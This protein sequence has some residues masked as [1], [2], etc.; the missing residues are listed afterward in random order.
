MTTYYVN[1]STGNDTNDGSST[2]PWKT[3]GKA[4]TSISASDTIKLSGS[5]TYSLSATFDITS[6]SVTI[7][8]DGGSSRPTIDASSATRAFFIQGATNVTLKNLII[9]GASADNV[10]V[11]GNVDGCLIEGCDLI[12][13]QNNDGFECD[14]V[15]KGGSA[16]SGTVI[17]RNCLVK[18]NLVDGV[19]QYSGAVIKCYGVV[20]DGHGDVGGAPA[21]A[22]NFTT[23]ETGHIEMYYCKS[24]AGKDGLHFTNTAGTNIV[25]GCSITGASIDPIKH[26]SA[27]GST[28]VRN[29]YIE[30]GALT[31]IY[32]DN[33]ANIDAYNN[34]VVMLSTFASGG[35]SQGA[36]HADDTG[37][38]MTVYNNTILNFSANQ[39]EAISTD[40]AAGNFDCRNNLTILLH[41]SAKHTDARITFASGTKEIDYNSYYPD[42]DPLVDG[43][44]FRRGGTEMTFSTTGTNWQGFSWDANGVVLTS[45]PIGIS[46]SSG[47]SRYSLI[48]IDFSE[49]LVGQNL[50]STFTN[51]MRG[52]KRVAT[53][54]WYVGCH[55]PKSME[56]NM[57]ALGI[58][59]YVGMNIRT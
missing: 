13:S 10:L 41:N 58:S 51:D 56:E 29:S 36:I 53:G 22:D 43:G 11:T 28:T 50:S 32:A 46:S 8:Q 33:G 52:N 42:N 18:D 23:H 38:T 19:S 2:S 54:S 17:L 35:I 31:G 4:E 21:N 9:D 48:P 27:S 15:S 16:T 49:L 3:L 39:G 59:I 5:Q 30:C 40:S 37:S 6:N 14:S 44:R 45:D 7:E 47:L 55:L 20:S 12:N 25:D 24:I 1:D 26:Q 34:E 57:D